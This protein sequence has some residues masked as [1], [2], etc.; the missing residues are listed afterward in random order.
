[1][2][3]LL[4]ISALL[5]ATN[6]TAQGNEVED[7]TVFFIDDIPVKQSILAQ[8][9]DMKGYKPPVDAQQERAQQMQSAQELINIYLLSS[10]AEKNGLDNN[11]NVKQS[12]E[13]SRRSILMKAMAEKYAAEIEVSD[14]ELE[15]AYATINKNSVIKADFKIRNI[16]V[17]QEKT[18]QEI[19]NKLK[20][21]ESFEQLEKQYS[22]EGFKESK[23]P[24]WIN[25]SMVQPEIAAAI[26]P[27]NKTE[28]TS[29]PVKTK[30]GWHVIY[31]VDKKPIPVPALDKIKQELTGLIKKKKLSEIVRNLRSKVSI[32]T[33][34]KA[35]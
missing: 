10:E 5:L 13:L 17:E 30:F 32:T 2:K 8:Y 19:I 18:A 34:D 3:A 28:F 25:S 22:P 26:V 9:H 29:E 7:K 27:L 31:L 24:E 20:S 16:I 21:G 4:M 1:M 11:Y 15:E 35:E 6:I 33:A 12:L 14:K 23:S